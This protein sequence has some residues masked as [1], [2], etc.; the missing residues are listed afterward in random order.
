MTTTLKIVKEGDY[1]VIAEEDPEKRCERYEDTENVKEREI[2]MKTVKARNFMFVLYNPEFIDIDE[3][4]IDKADVLYCIYGLELCPKTKTEH[5]QGYIEFKCPM[6]YKAA[7][8][9][10]YLD[11]NPS[12]MARRGTQKQAIDYVRKQ[13]SK[14]VDDDGDFHIWEYGVPSVQGRRKDIHNCIEMIKEGKGIK[15]IAEEHPLEYIKYYKGFEK[16]YATLEIPMD[17]YFNDRE[18]QVE[19]YWGDAGVGK[20]RKAMSGDRRKIFK[21]DLVAGTNIWWDGYIGQS[22][23]LLDEF[24]DT[25]IE[26]TYFLKMTDR[27]PLTLNVKNSMVKAKYTKVIITSQCHPEEWYPMESDIRREAVMRRLTKIEHITNE[28]K[29]IK[30]KS[31]VDTDYEKVINEKH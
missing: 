8:A 12:F 7:Q 14:I 10:F 30:M 28:P 16:L 29:I 23:L 18:I 13:E 19:V 20:T 11:G 1:R 31:P 3:V 27:Y 22:T 2:W 9:V 17:S 5:L 4:L 24:K 25:L 15:S 26:V 21:L 6:R